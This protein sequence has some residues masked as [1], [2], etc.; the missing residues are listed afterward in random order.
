M[1]L[2]LPLYRWLAGGLGLAGEPELG[3]AW[4]GKE[5]HETGFFLDAFPVL[6][7]EQGLEE[8]RAIVRRVRAGD[9]REPGR[10]PYD[11]IFKAIFG[12]STLGVEGEE[13][14]P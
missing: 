12:L 8:A 7:L 6:E 9:F 14:G 2:Q 5:D 3:Y 13:Q 11:E 1:D 10:A 4:I